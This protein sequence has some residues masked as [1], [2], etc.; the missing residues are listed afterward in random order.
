MWNSAAQSDPSKK[1]VQFSWRGIEDPFGSQW[2]FEDGIQKHQ[3]ATSG[4]Y[5][6]SGYWIT[7]DTSKYSE[8]DSNKGAGAETGSFPESG[9]TGANLVWVHHAF[10][11]EAGYISEFDWKTFFPTAVSGSSTTYLCDYAHN[12]TSDAGCAVSAG[13]YMNQGS[14]A[15]AGTIILQYAM[16]VANASIGSRISA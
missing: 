10:P 16:A 7:S 2:C 11:K 5:S 8:L 9:Y 12:N 14:Y 3:N 4:D 15:G 6:Q 1:V 13:G